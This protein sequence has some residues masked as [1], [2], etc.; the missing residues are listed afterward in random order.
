M[1]DDGAFIEFWFNN[2]KQLLTMPATPFYNMDELD[3]KV[4]MKQGLY[5]CRL[6]SSCPYS[7]SDPPLSIYHDGMEFTVWSDVLSRIK[8]TSLDRINGQ[9]RVLTP[10]YQLTQSSLG[11]DPEWKIFHYV[12]KENPEHFDVEVIV[13]I[14][15][16]SNS[17]Y[18]I[19]VGKLTYLG[20]KI[21]I[22]GGSQSMTIP[23]TPLGQIGS[24][25]VRFTIP[26]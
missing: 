24:G 1:E 23:A 16:V 12:W 4:Y 13:G 21:D 2:K 22:D 26:R 3:G 20:I 7:S 5:H 25:F 9:D 8:I 15:S 18:V 10:V 11:G 6:Q 19:E 14:V 17:E